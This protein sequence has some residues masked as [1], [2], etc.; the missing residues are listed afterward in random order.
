[1]FLP[2]MFF[3]QSF[4]LPQHSMKNLETK[5]ISPSYAIHG[6]IIAEDSTFK[7]WLKDTSNRIKNDLAIEQRFNSAFLNFNTEIGSDSTSFEII[8]NY[9]VQIKPSN[10]GKHSNDVARIIELLREYDE[11]PSKKF[12]LL[13]STSNYYS[14]SMSKNL[15][16][17]N[18][19]EIKELRVIVEKPFSVNSYTCIRGRINSKTQF[20]KA[21][22]KNLIREYNFIWV[23]NNLV[24]KELK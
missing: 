7:N 18:L 20:L 12:I 9:I 11:I 2:I 5:V 14:P 17:D 16:Y 3:I 22:D 21:N 8:K 13:F 23:G 4:F 10:I 6:L 1:M 19:F 24:K 15:I